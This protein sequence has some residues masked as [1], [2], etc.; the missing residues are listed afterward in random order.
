MFSESSYCGS[1]GC[2]LYAWSAGPSLQDATTPPVILLHGGGPDHH[3]FVPLAQ[4]LAE[5]HHVILPDIRGYGLSVCTDPAYHTWSQYVSDLVSLLDHFKIEAAVIGG[6]GLGATITLRI[7]LASPD[8]IRAAILISVED[9]EDDEDKAAEVQLMD[10]F[11][12][13]VKSRSILE[14]WEPLLSQLAPLIGTLVREAI[15]RSTPESIAAA[16]AIGRDR[17]FLNIDELAV[18]KIPTLIFSGMD[19]RH[20]PTLAKEVANLLPRAELATVSVSEDILNADDL[21]KKFSP[22]I[23]EFLSK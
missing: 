21:A 23:I 9:I 15:P 22:P 17:S 6:A 3:M 16:A 2:T 1:D 8:R 5:R 12:A 14:A 7:A 11:A 20:P 10:E 18:I 4:R 19:F 13:S